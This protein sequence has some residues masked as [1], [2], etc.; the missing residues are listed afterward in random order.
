MQML[1]GGFLLTIAGLGT[2]ELRGFD[3][4]NV[5]D[6]STVALG[7]L[8][9]VGSVVGF[10]SYV[11]LL[12]VAPLPRIATYAYVNPVV[13]VFLGAL[14]LSEPITPRTLAASAVIIVGVVLIVTGRSR[15]AAAP[16]IA[17]PA[18]PT[19]PADRPLPRPRFA[20][21]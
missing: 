15:T 1:A 16:S 9:F 17:E 19:S 21:K 2:G 20:G 12:R 5:S 13:A 14:I 10:T 11:W 8:I 6:S 18:A 3:V 7:Y 4:G